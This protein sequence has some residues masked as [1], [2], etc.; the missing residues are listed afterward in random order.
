M[1]ADPGEVAADLDRIEAS[2]AIEAW[3]WTGEVAADFGRP[4]WLDLAAERAERLARNAGSYADGMRQAAARRLNTWEAAIARGGDLP[5]PPSG[6]T[7]P[8]TSP[9]DRGR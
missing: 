9:R 4:D 5:G 7:D 3:W 6:P 8:V 1:P 2:V